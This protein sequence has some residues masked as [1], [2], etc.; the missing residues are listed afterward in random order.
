MAP[1]D[2]AFAGPRSDVIGIL[3]AAGSSR[4]F[5]ADKL[6]QPLTTEGDWVAVRACSNLLA[7]AGRVVAV[8]RPGSEALA[9]RLRQIG[10]EILIFEHA[11]M[12]MG[13]SIAAGVAHGRN[14]AGW[15][16]ALADM[17]WIEPATIRSV[18]AAIMQG[19]GMA[20]PSFEG[21]RGHPVGF[22]SNY[23]EDLLNL[24][25]DQGARDLLQVNKHALKLIDCHDPG[26]LLD[27][28][29]PEDLRSRRPDTQGSETNCMPSGEP[30]SS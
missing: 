21:R 24:S 7:G 10:A 17:P 19:A 9:T 8:V 23:R 28:D 14:A 11:G 27:I 13:A 22:A 2:S 18:A 20:A 3:L 30:F 6:T 15:L 5:G 25:G 4:R 1:V 12:G 26:V 16:I 29:T